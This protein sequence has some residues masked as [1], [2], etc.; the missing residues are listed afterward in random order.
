MMIKQ[1]HY[2]LNTKKKTFM[3]KVSISEDKPDPI[4]IQNT[5]VN[6]NTKLIPSPTF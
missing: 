6:A 2:N 1:I 5:N 3:K 4:T